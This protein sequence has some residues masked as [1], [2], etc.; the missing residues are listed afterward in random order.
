MPFEEAKAKVKQEMEKK[1]RKLAD[2]RAKMEDDE[3][4]LNSLKKHLHSRFGDAI[5]LEY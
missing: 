3:A 1:L 2:L 4:Q 5:R